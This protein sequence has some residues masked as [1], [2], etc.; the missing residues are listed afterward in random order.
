MLRGTGAAA[1]IALI[2]AVG[3]LGGFMGPYAMGWMRDAFGDFHVGL[4]I[5][6]AAAV[7]GGVMV[8]IVGAPRRVTKSRTAAQVTARSEA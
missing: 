7:L 5:L 2:N 6:S 1:G 8:L 3:N 4:R